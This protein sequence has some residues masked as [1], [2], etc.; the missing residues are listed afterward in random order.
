MGDDDAI[1]LALRL[2]DSAAEFDSATGGVNIADGLYPV[3]KLINADGCVV[4]P[5]ER[6]GRLYAERVGAKGV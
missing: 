3:V 1:V 4:V 2:L 5:A 6:L